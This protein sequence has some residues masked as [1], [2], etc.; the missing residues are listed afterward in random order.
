MLFNFISS[1]HTLI[2]TPRQRMTID[3]ML[4][5]E[6]FRLPP[7]P[8]VPDFSRRRK[9]SLMVLATKFRRGSTPLAPNNRIT[10]MNDPSD[11]S[12]Y[13]KCSTTLPDSALRNFSS[14]NRVSAVKTNASQV[15]SDTITS[16]VEEKQVNGEAN[17]NKKK[18]AKGQSFDVQMLPS[19]KPSVIL[20][21]PDG[22][23]VEQG[24]FIMLPTC[25]H[26]LTF[27]NPL[28]VK[29]REKLNQYGI[30]SKMLCDSIGMNS[31]SAIIGIYRVVMHRVLTEEYIWDSL[32]DPST[33][34]SKVHCDRDKG[35][36]GDNEKRTLKQRISRACVLLW[37]VRSTGSLR[38][39]WLCILLHAES[40]CSTHLTVQLRNLT[41]SP[42][43]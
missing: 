9:N 33:L 21:C 38:S 35:K 22:T 34:N 7:S 12:N 31:K 32:S 25:T 24:R 2:Q 42:S 20:K 28:E 19:T 29:T 17:S 23:P 6:W 3:E 10:D 37:I 8:P 41:I 5:C 13:R 15:N 11:R 36:H 14:R 30:D 43:T 39:D 26:D 1:E 40:P 4:E 18:L 16:I 27:L